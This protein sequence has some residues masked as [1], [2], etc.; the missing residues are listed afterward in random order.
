MAR[1]MR[2]VPTRDVFHGQEWQALVLANLE[3]LDDVGMDE[4][5]GGLGLV[6]QPGAFPQTG[7]LASENHLQRHDPAKVRLP[8]LVDDPHA[9]PADLVENLVVANLQAAAG[10]IARVGRQVSHSLARLPLPA[11]ES[12]RVGISES[13]TMRSASVCSMRGSN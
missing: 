4:L 3:D 2:E 5:G 9:S 1:S 10:L 6:A 13:N 7:V 12:V 8:G 11:E